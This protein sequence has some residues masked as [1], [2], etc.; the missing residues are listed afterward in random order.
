M[1][2]LFGI[3]LGIALT[4]GGAYLYDSH[5]ALTAQS[6]E[7]AKEQPLVNWDVVSQKWNVLSDRARVQ[8]DHLSQRARVEWNHHIG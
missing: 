5:N 1:R 4:I 6:T 8:W 2:T 3:I 7:T